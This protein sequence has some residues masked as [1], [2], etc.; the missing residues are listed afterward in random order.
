MRKTSAQFAALFLSSVALS[1]YAD[2]ER[3]FSIDEF[4][5][6]S[7]SQGINLNL[8]MGVSP[9]GYCRCREGQRSRSTRDRS[10]RRCIGNSTGLMG[11]Q[12]FQHG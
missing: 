2:V 4:D 9:L 11:F 1:T 12:P 3:D 7:V 10:R 5:S 6:V 8:V